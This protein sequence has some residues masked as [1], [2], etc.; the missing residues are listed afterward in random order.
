MNGYK[1]FSKP[2]VF[3]NVYHRTS[4]FY[5]NKYSIVKISGFRRAILHVIILLQETEEMQFL[6]IFT[7]R[8][9]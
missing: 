3:F 6:H 1:Q 5:K 8:I 9:Q 2:K 7:I 4:L